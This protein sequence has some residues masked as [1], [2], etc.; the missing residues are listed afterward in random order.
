VRA[1]VTGG[2]GYVGVPFVRRLLDEGWDVTLATRRRDNAARLPEAVSVYEVDLPDT[3]GMQRIAEGE[4]RFDVVFHLG[5]SLTYFGERGALQRANVQGTRNVLELAARTGSGRFVYASSIEAVGTVE[6]VPAPPDVPCRPVSEYGRS[7]VDAEGQVRER[8]E[9]RF[10]YTIL[11][12][13]NVYDSDQYSFLPEIADAIVLRNRLFEFLPVYADRYLHPVHN[14]DVS[15]GLLAAARSEST[16]VTATLGGEAVT[17]GEMFQ[18]AADVLGR[19]LYPRERRK[20]DELFL[21][22]RSRYHRRRRTMDLITYIMAGRGRRVHRAYDIE[23]TVRTLGF[24]PSMPFRQ[25]MMECL[26]WARESGLLA[27]EE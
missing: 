13:G 19:P 24:R 26:Q 25:G 17:V 8:A 15:E 14:R 18:I 1:F 23:H 3:E 10:P 6:H 16:G 2:T 22:I 5:A 9:G 27:S 7:K 20:S 11:R 12:I 4:R 21:R